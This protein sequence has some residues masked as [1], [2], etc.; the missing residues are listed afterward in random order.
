MTLFSVS[1]RARVAAV[2]LKQSSA[3]GVEVVVGVAFRVSQLEDSER[4]ALFDYYGSYV[5]VALAAVQRADP[6]N[7]PMD[8]E[9]ARVQREHGQPERMRPGHDES[10]LDC[11]KVIG[12]DP[13]AGF[14][15]PLAG[16]PS[17]LCGACVH[18]RQGEE[19][20]AEMP[21]DTD[22]A[23]QS[24]CAECRIWLAVPTGGICEVCGKG[25]TSEPAEDAVNLK[26]DWQQIADGEDLE[27]ASD[28]GASDEAEESEDRPIGD[29]PMP[30]RPEGEGLVASTPI[31][32]KH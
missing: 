9:L 10:C 26:A 32:R 2:G 5:D 1:G 11:G 30:E 6:E 23:N 17:P 19:D 28:S 13:E 22:P 31:R 4:S 18:E 3:F 25:T 24:W 15:V 7:L 12:D 29:G 16:P 8:E 14:H 27:P 21:A 20:A